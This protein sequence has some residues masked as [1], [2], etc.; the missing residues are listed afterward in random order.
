MI[1][2]LPKPHVGSGKGHNF[3]SHPE[4]EDP[5]RIERFRVKN[6]Q[7]RRLLNPRLYNEPIRVTPL[8]MPGRTASAVH[9]DFSARRIPGK[10]PGSAVAAALLLDDLLHARL[11][12]HVVRL[13]I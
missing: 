11:Q 10:D 5:Q 7:M 4:C 12:L 8:K 13:Y 6:T 2:A 9:H 1:P 3:R